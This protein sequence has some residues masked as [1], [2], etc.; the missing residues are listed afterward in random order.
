MTRHSTSFEIERPV[1][2][3]KA[4][5]ELVPQAP[6]PVAVP[7]APYKSRLRRLLMAGAA[8]AVLSGAAWFGWD[9]WTV[10]RFQ[11]ST[12]DAYVKADT[13]VIAPKVSGYLR[14]VLVGDNESV[15]AGQVLARIDERDFQVA[16]DQAKADVAAARAAIA[17][18]QAQLDT[19]RTVIDAARATLDVD[20]ATSTTCWLVTMSGSRPAR[21]WPGSTTAT[22][23][24]RST[25]P[26]PTSPPPAP[27]SPASRPSSTFNRR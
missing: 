16:L 24:S 15:V 3:A 4:A 9:Y 1:P 23:R 8:L 11:V 18:K 14:E 19:Q 5:P 17:S 13:T 2:A 7:P 20:T 25:R 21:C 27:R 6:A 22:S 26:R 12:D 10:G